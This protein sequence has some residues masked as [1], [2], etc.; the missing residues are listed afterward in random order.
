V[1]WLLR[2]TTIGFRMRAVGANP[3]AARYAGMNVGNT[4]MLS[5]GMAGALAGLAGATQLLGVPPSYSLS[6]PFG[7]AGIGFEAIALALLGRASPAGVVASSFLFA[8]M[9]TGSTGMQAVTETPVDII[10]VIQA[11][12][13][14]FVA[15]PALVR[16]IFRIRTARL[17]EGQTFTTNWGSG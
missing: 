2:H 11:L 16:A 4:Y 3:N 1:W 14:V 6:S 7:A 9:R 13:I 15:A 12:I 17:G 5:M 10:Q 8:V